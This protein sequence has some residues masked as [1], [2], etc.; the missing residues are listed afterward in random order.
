MFDIEGK[1]ICLQ[2]LEIHSPISLTGGRGGSLKF[3]GAE[4]YEIQGGK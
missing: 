3:L 4:L 2:I 1:M